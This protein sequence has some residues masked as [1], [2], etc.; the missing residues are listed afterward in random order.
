MKYKITIVVETESEESAQG[1][2]DVAKEAI[3]DSLDYNCE[4]FIA[5]CVEPESA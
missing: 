1:I 2:L 5:G 3:M 4:D